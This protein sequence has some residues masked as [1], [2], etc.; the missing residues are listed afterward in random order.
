MKVLQAA[1][2]FTEAKDIPII[3][4]LTSEGL[5]AELLYD[6]SGFYKAIPRAGLINDGTFMPSF[7]ERCIPYLNDKKRITKPLKRNGSDFVEI[8]FSEA[9]DI[10]EKAIKQVNPNENAFFA[11]ARLSNEALYLIQKFA[12]AGVKSNNIGSFHYLGRNATHYNID[13]NDN[14]Q[15]SEIENCTSIVLLGT[16]VKEK[17]G[18]AWQ[19]MNSYNLPCYFIVEKD[20]IPPF[21]RNDDALLGIRGGSSSGNKAAAASASCLLQ[22]PSFRPKGGIYETTN[23]YHFIKALNH[24]IITNNLQQGIFVE[25]LVK[26]QFLKYKE[27]L[28]AEDF[29]SLLEKAGISAS[30]ISE[31]AD[32]YL[33]DKRCVIVF[34]EQDVTSHTVR[35]LLNL[36][37]L[38]GKSGFPSSGILSLK[39]KNNAQGLFDM[40]IFSH[41][42]IGG[43][44]FNNA[45][46]QIM[47]NVW[48]TTHIATEIIDNEE[49]LCSGKSKNL[50]I[51]G[52]DPLGCIR[53][54]VKN[55]LSNIIVQSIDNAHF[56][57]VQD[58]F[59]TETALKADLIL[60]DTFPFETGGSFTNTIKIVQSFT[61]V[62]PSP[63]EINNL[64]QLSS[65]C[66]R[67]GLSP[68]NTLDDIFLEM[69]TFLKTECSGGSRHQFVYTQ[70]DS[71]MPLF[72][73]GCDDLMKKSMISKIHF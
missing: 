55:D 68:C 10:I 6:D 46:I 25:E 54:Q 50:F 11:G 20:K 24:H 18:M 34:S 58:Y 73:A 30:E 38:T 51:F 44:I 45:F 57:M 36:C 67:F 28:L 62:I 17:S 19:M 15:F 29:E 13:K 61:E 64:Q 23:Y 35:E 56:I 14:V 39:E 65:L 1:S 43:N 3:D 59:L 33:K 16:A 47:K 40:G 5:E 4:F 8:S 26:E 49:Y 42:G 21:G 32:F 48:K 66:Q 52:E 37:L 69:I 7:L 60:P 70:K 22:S 72:N 53:N 71:N 31:F 41:I 27:Q 9:F 12:R 2:G 63:V